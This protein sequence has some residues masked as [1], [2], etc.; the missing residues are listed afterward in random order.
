LKLGNYRTFHRPL[1][2][3]Y[4][5][6]SC[7]TRWPLPKYQISFKLEKHFEDGRMGIQTYE[8]TLKPALLS[9][10]QISFPV[11]RDIPHLG[12]ADP[13]LALYNI[14][15]RYDY[16]ESRSRSSMISMSSPSRDSSLLRVL[17]M[18]ADTGSSA[19]VER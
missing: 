17:A 4:D 10:L 11:R 18:S 5:I 3:S 12:D 8:R 14:K 2:G 7:I 15:H 13:Q 16:T 19:A 6:P 9:Q 1:I